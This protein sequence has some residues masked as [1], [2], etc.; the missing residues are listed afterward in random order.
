MY[1]LPTLQCGAG[2]QRAVPP[3]FLGLWH[4]FACGALYRQPDYTDLRGKFSFACGALYR[5]AR[6]GELPAALSQQ[7]PQLADIARCVLVGRLCAGRLR[8]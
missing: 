8:G 1:N 7:F 3:I 5:Q 6:L 4:S 2:L